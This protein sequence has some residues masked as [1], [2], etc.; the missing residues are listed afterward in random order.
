MKGIVKLK[1]IVILVQWPIFSFAK[2]AAWLS[3]HIF[4]PDVI[5]M[6]TRRGNHAKQLKRD[7]L[8]KSTP[9]FWYN[10]GRIMNSS[11][12]Q[13]EFHMIDGSIQKRGSSQYQHSIWYNWKI[14]TIKNKDDI[15]HY[16]HANTCGSLL[17]TFLWVHAFIKCVSQAPSCVSLVLVILILIS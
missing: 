2:P 12:F 3:F 14:M 16:G 15:T 4:S 17:W 5:S 7:S 10:S 13:C 9:N 1:N 6:G 8:Y 11:A